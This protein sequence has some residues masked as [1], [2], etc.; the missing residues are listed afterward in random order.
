MLELAIFACKME[1]MREDGNPLWEGRCSIVGQFR[2]VWLK[3]RNLFWFV[4]QP[5]VTGSP[6][7]ISEAERFVLVGKE[8]RLCATSS[9]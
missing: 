5:S 8:I 3:Y 1:N 7:S 6:F 2:C 4:S 9:S